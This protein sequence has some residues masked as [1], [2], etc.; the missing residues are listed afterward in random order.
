MSYESKMVTG[1]K[2][3]STAHSPNRPR[4]RGAP[5]LAL[6]MSKTTSLATCTVLRLLS[7]VNIIE[8]KYISLIYMNTWTRIIGQ[9]PDGL[10]QHNNLDKCEVLGVAQGAGERLLQA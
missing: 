2:L 1:P 4:C 10:H 5:H 6:I 9:S 8:C 7:A 3:Y